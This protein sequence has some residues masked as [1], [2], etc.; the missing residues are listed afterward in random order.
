MSPLG[1][2]DLELRDRHIVIIAGHKSHGPEHNNIHDYPAQARLIEDICRRSEVGSQLI[3]TR[4]E[5]DDWPSKA[6][7]NADCVVI[8]GD[9]RDGDLGYAE[10][11]HLS[12]PQRISELEEAVSRGAGVVPIHFSI[13]ASEAD[14]E[15]VLRWQGGAF[16]WEQNGKRDWFSIITWERGALKALTD[17]PVLNG[18]SEEM[19]HEEYYHK[20]AFHESTIPLI[21]VSSLPGENDQEKAVAWVIEEESGRRSFGTSMGHS[22]K[23]FRCDAFRTLLTNGIVWSAGLSI[24]KDGLQVPFAE[25]EDVN[26]RLGEGPKPL[27]I[28]VVVLAGNNAHRWHNWP[29]STAAL[30]RAWGDDPRIETCVI[31]EPA[32]LP[33]ALNNADVLVLN[34][35][36][37]EDPS[38]MPKN[39][40]SAIEKFTERGG[41]VFVHHFANGACHSSLPGAADSDWPWYRTLVRRIWNHHGNSKHDAYGSFQVKVESNHPLVSELKAFEVEDEL[42]FNQEGDLPIDA[43]LTATSNVSGKPEPLLWEY[44]VNQGRVVQSLLGHSGETYKTPEMQVLACRIIAWCAKRH[45]HGAAIN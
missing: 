18:V 24:P 35:V 16:Q 17:H 26:Y 21:A 39:S 42:Y 34:W 9:G 45:L 41:G 14:L 6:I 38:G 22:L 36:N 40:Q 5:N 23:S 7:E 15:R 44:T 13:F 11:S 25:R 10:A 27:P 12:S 20:L 2:T 19:M 37:W 8:I 1:A 31:T 4:A 28:R 29:E 33:S 3:I 43:L 32:D 30:L